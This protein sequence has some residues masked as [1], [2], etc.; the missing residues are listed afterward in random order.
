MTLNEMKALY[1]KANELYHNGGKALMTDKEFDK[2]EAK[3]RERAPTWS[4]LRETGAKISKKVGTKLACL[5]PSLAKFYPDAADKLLAKRKDLKWLVM[6]KLDGGSLQLE[7]MNGKPVRAVTRGNGTIGGDISFLLP[8]LNIPSSLPKKS[9]I[10][11]RCEALMNKK[12]FASKYEDKFK[13][14]R[15]MV[16]GWLNRR[17]PDPNLK[18]VSIVV[19]GIYDMPMRKGLKQAEVWGFDVVDHDVMVL[20]SQERLSSVLAE[21]RA[22]SEFEMDGLVLCD[23]DHVLKYDSVD[24]PKWINAYKEND[25]EDD[26]DEATVKRIIWQSSRNDLLIPKIEIEPLEI[27]GTTVTYCTSHNAKWMKERGIG[28]GAIIKIV[29]SGDVIPKIIGVV[30]KGKFQPPTVRYEEKGVHF[31]ALERS[32]E[33]EVRELLHFF[34]T[35]GIEFIASKT[36]E[37]LYDAGFTSVLHHIEAFGQKTKH[38]AKIEMP[39]FKSETTMTTGMLRYKKAGIG[40]AMSA[41][42]FMEAQRI[43]EDEGITLLK[44]MNASNCFESFGERKLAL[45]QS[46][47]MAK[48]DRDPLKGYLQQTQEWLMNERN[49]EDLKTIKG[50]GEASARQFFEGIQRFKIWFRPIFKTRLLKF[51][52]PPFVSGKRVKAR[53]FGPLEGKKV[54]FT[55]YRNK[56]HEAWIEERGGEIVSF[57]TGTKIDILIYKEGGKSSL[58][59]EKARNLNKRVCTFEEFKK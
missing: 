14:A 24:R 38:R 12:L 27:G 42:I 9:H 41:K 47:Y 37:K 16:N 2:L 44:L 43:L 58:K 18:K 34:K 5:M 28:P 57:G 7:Y 10:V 23:P 25:D 33:S 29:R 53:K 19:L 46:H 21:T 49:W 59:V 32:K 36:V 48:G 30:K 13:N 35:M 4:E 31:V 6:S 15:N 45:I 20:S 1:I 8:Y 39:G 3:I 54:C 26:A 22:A 55:G 52:E 11:L 40:L 50:M 56:D 17:K 51:N